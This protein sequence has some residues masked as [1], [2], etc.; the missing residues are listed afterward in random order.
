[1]HTATFFTHVFVGSYI[2]RYQCDTWCDTTDESEYMAMIAQMQTAHM[3]YKT[4]L[5]RQKRSSRCGLSV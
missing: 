3:E 4:K 1:M 2:Y 5:A